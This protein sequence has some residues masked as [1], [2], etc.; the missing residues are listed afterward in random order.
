[1]LIS[2]TT[3][4]V[5]TYTL[6]WLCWQQQCSPYGANIRETTSL[7]DMIV[8]RKPDMSLC[9]APVT[10]EMSS[11]DILSSLST[12]FV[13]PKT[14]TNTYASVHKYIISLSVETERLPATRI[15]QS[16]SLIALL[17]KKVFA[18]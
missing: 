1:M 9:D 3:S 11:R 18:S 16:L 8:L 5:V 17:I 15:L 2:Y 4:L 13:H 14:H 10:L 12:L 6:E 7:I